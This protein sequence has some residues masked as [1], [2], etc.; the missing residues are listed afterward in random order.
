MN[1]YVQKDMEGKLFSNAGDE[2][3]GVGNVKISGR[4]NQLAFVKRVTKDGKPY[5]DL[6]QSVG[7]IYMN[8]KTTPNHPDMGGTV[9]IGGDTLRASLWQNTTQYGASYVSVKV[10]PKEPAKDIPF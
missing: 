8:Q 5:Y 7:K 2:L 4:D 6:M 3:I 1:K 9:E 10:S